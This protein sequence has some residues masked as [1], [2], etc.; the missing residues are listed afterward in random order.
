MIHVVL[1]FA[2]MLR[3]AIDLELIAVEYIFEHLEN[4]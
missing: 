1:N 4:C 3:F 2:G